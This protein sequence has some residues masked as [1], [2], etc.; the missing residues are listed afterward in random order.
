MAPR[1]GS[2]FGCARLILLE[3][4]G[5][6]GFSDPCVV[7]RTIVGLIAIISQREIER[8]GAFHAQAFAISSTGN[9]LQ[10]WGTGRPQIQDELMVRKQRVR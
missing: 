6:S 9:G 7:A 1:G 5:F 4:T 8:A 3:D 2:A 10:V